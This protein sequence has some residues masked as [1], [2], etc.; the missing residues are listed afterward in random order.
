MRALVAVLLRSSIFTKV[1]SLWP[2]LSPALQ[3][4]VKSAL[5][6]AIMREQVEHIRHKLV[7]TTAELAGA[8]FNATEQAS[9]RD[10]PEMM[11]FL[12]QA[13]SSQN[14]G[15][16]EAA[17]R[18]FTR[19]ANFMQDA[20]Q[21]QNLN[22]VKQIFV[23]GMMEDDMTVRLS[24]M[25]ACISF[26]EINFDEASKKEFQKLLP[27][28]AEIITRCLTVHKEE[29]ARI[30]IGMFVEL[31]EEDP[32]YFRPVIGSVCELMAKIITTQA[33]EDNTRQL[34]LELLV[35]LCECKPGMM[36]KVPNFIPSLFNIC[37]AMLL[38][39][40]DDKEWLARTADSVEAS[41][42]DV[43][44]ESLDR[45]C[46]C[47]SGKVVMPIMSRLLP[48]LLKS[49]NWKQRYAALQAICIMGEGCNEDMGDNLGDFTSMV[50]PFFSDEHP[51]VR[52]AALNTLGQMCTDFGPYLQEEHHGAIFPKLLLQMETEQVPKVQAHCCACIIN[53]C[54]NLDP[55]ALGP[56]LSRLMNAL[57][58]VIK[59]GA[60]I[61]QEQAL[62]ALCAVAECLEDKFTPFYDA[63][64]PLCKTVLLKAN[65]K[66]FR[67][68]QGKAIDAITIMAAAVGSEKFQLD[69][70][71]IL[72][73]MVQ[74]QKSNM[75]PDDPMIGHLMQGWARICKCLKENF[76]PYL[77]IVMPQL[78]KSAAMQP[79]VQIATAENFES[80]QEEGNWDIKPVA[81]ESV[82][83][84]SSE[85][86]E[87]TLACNMIY[88]YAYDLEEH[89]MPY[90][91]DAA[92]ILVP[93]LNFYLDEKTRQAVAGTIPRLLNC[94]V[95][96]TV[97][98][99]AN[100][101]MV[102]E[103][104]NAMLPV[105][106]EAIDAEQE[107]TTLIAKLDGIRD[108]LEVLGKG[109]L[110]MQ[111]LCRCLTMFLGVSMRCLK[112]K[113]DLSIRQNEE[114][115]DEIEQQLVDQENIINEQTLSSL[116]DVHCQMIKAAPQFFM[117]CL[118][119]LQFDGNTL[120]RLILNMAD[121]PIT[122]TDL[123]ISICMMDDIIEFGGPAAGPLYAQFI[124]CLMKNMDHQSTEVRQAAVYGIGVFFEVSNP[125]TVQ[126][127]LINSL[128]KKLHGI[129]VGKNSRKKSNVMATENAISAFGKAIE[130]K[131]EMLQDEKSAVEMFVN[132]LPL[133]KDRVEAKIVHARFVRMVLSNRKFI[134]GENFSL[135]P[136]IFN[137]LLTVL[138]SKLVSKSLN[139]QI[140]QAVEAIRKNIPGP[141]VQQ[142]FVQLPQELKSK[143]TDM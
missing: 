60:V 65:G 114:D 79:E 88:C 132:F 45:L 5:L 86:Q 101:A 82:A 64:M 117:E 78:L 98:R 77:Q 142:A 128:V 8:I 46:L 9:I 38:E 52:Y 44:S 116:A 24:C 31:A 113:Y 133:K 16:R 12:F 102:G 76:V 140:L 90:V 134:F 11:Q 136:K 36:R 135:L 93:L 35:T 123:Q 141:A 15:H 21:G 39:L 48:N 74:L 1:D 105:I 58:G 138:G 81:D 7:D 30:A 97:K 37:L 139:P 19:L 28:M 49:P 56:Y 109:C 100:P 40:E 107:P 75:A 110:T 92:K 55:T 23:K 70:Q 87:K 62:V 47:L 67:E 137:I 68:L 73:A 124:P 43:A 10:W 20:M 72:P 103:L 84:R 111:D 96:H 143:L 25:S 63:F 131:A 125:Q 122:S 69:A 106:L 13:S 127:Q 115:F 4:Q 95:Q 59:N 6:Q 18:M 27:K 14:P 83:V 89:F 80:L 22:M 61:A 120:L 94:V 126:P 104:W 33:L 99:N 121:K 57:G 51:R 129:V 118:P 32:L 66:K 119:K 112:R 130:F 41:N 71:Q 34:A 17:F 29:E 26:I 2:R 42:S 53:W 3:N 50:V 108:C 91:S 54:E 85:L